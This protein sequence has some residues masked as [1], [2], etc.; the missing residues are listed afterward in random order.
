MITYNGAVVA[1]Q[2]KPLVLKIKSI[3]RAAFQELVRRC[4]VLRV[5]PLAYACTATPFGLQETAFTERAD[6]PTTE[7]NGSTVRQVADLL[8]IKEDIVAVLIERPTGPAGDAL[9]AELVAIFAGILRVTTSGGPYIE[10]CHREA[11]K[12]N[13]TFE[14]V[15]M[16]GL[17]MADV[18]AIGDNF[19]DLEMIEAAGV[20][21]AVANSPE[22]VK[23]VATLNCSQAGARGV[24]EALRVLTSVLRTERRL[25]KALSKRSSGIRSSL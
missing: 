21:V 10:V 5:S 7:F 17:E 13:A 25:T 12:R 19:N 20:G 8:Q 24:V 22:P 18:M 1:L 2:E 3:E 6:G 9:L 11:T 15:Q 14:L 4:K 23:A 16:L